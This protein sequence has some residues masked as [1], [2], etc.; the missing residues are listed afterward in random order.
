MLKKKASELGLIT[1][2]DL[3]RLTGINWMRIYKWIEGGKIPAPTHQRE[4]GKAKYYTVKEAEKVVQLIYDNLRPA[5]LRE[6]LA[7]RKK[8]K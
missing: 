2:V 5:E 3:E 7:A 8:V 4:G 6:L 1:K